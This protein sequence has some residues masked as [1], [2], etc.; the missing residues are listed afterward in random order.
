[1]KKTLLLLVWALTAL[2]LFGQ[3]SAG[4]SSVGNKP[5]PAAVPATANPGPTA[6]AVDEKTLKITD[7]SPAVPGTPAP[8]GELTVWD[9]L[10]M[11]LI[12]AAVIGMI[13]GF[14]YLLKKISGQA[15]NANNPIKVLHTHVLGGSRTLYLVEV[16]EEI[17]LIGSGDS[18]VSLI[19]QIDSQ[20]TI[21]AIRL[22]ASQN[23][24]SQLGKN[25]G[26]IL[27]QLM[28]KKDRVFPK[29]DEPVDNSADFLKKQRERLKKL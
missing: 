28:G 15:A 29:V 11:F 5:S 16:G 24:V 12:L 10:R 6:P 3:S 4:Q 20:E 26:S 23:Q 14:I 21:D 2:S 25:F 18:S 13:V 1:M 8:T 9:F 17:L 7:T 19:K 27:G 22:S